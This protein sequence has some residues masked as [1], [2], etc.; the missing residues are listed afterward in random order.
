MLRTRL[1]VATKLGCDP[2]GDVNEGI[3]GEGIVGEV[4][5][6]KQR[7]DGPPDLRDGDRRSFFEGARAGA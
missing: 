4:M 3:V 5:Q 6:R 2:E 1:F 7:R